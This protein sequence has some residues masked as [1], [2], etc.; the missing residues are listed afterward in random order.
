[1]TGYS[2]NV[3]DRTENL[4]HLNRLLGVLV[5]GLGGG[6]ASGTAGEHGVAVLVQLELGDDAVGWVDA[7]LDGGTVDLMFT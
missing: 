7:D 6:A 1:M 4:F 2:L 3:S 5:L